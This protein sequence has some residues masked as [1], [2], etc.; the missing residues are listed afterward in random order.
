MKKFTKCF[1]FCVLCLISSITFAK[2]SL[3]QNSDEKFSIEFPENWDLKYPKNNVLIEASNPANPATTFNLTLSPLPDLSG[4]GL[5][6]VNPLDLLTVEELFNQE[7]NILIDSQEITVSG[8]KAF[9]IEF[10]GKTKLLELDI[11]I[12]A[13]QVFTVNNNKILAISAAAVAQTEDEAKVNLDS[14]RADFISTVKSLKL[15]DPKIFK[16]LSRQQ[17]IRIVLF[18]IFLYM[19]IVLSLPLILRIF[20]LKKCL[21]MTSSLA[22]AL[23]LCLI[24]TIGFKLVNI[25]SPILLNVLFSAFA[26]FIFKRK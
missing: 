12:R 11:G 18:K 6:G 24:Y 15:N 8:Q 1:I 22:S 19:S 4:L 26:F 21:D 25:P 10:K 9:M 20:I 16:K 23:L 5:K 17:F 14:V 2:N 7:S 3:Y 13:I